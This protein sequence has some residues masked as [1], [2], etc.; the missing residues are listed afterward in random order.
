M[1]EADTEF[2]TIEQLKAVVA[3][4]K[5][6]SREIFL[7]AG[8][9]DVIGAVLEHSHTSFR[10]QCK[11]GKFDQAFLS[12]ISQALQMCLQLSGREEQK[13]QM[14]QAEEVL[15]LLESLHRLS[16]TNPEKNVTEATAAFAAT[17]SK[18]MSIEESSISLDENVKKKRESCL[19]NAK[20]SVKGIRVQMLQKARAALTAAGLGGP[21]GSSWK[22]SLSADSSMTAISKAAETLMSDAYVKKL[23]AAFKLAETE[24]GFSHSS[25]ALTRTL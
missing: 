17:S 18:Y 19:N 12:A 1:R 2:V 10:T 16:N 7:S 6:V 21:D 20:E 15:L 11:E 13:K 9:A 5:G 24:P 3:S 8:G 25:Q 14:A 23:Y 4:F 22:T